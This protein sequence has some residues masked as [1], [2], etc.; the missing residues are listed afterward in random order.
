MNIKERLLEAFYR[1]AG[2]YREQMVSFYPTVGSRGIIECNQTHLFLIS[3]R[4]IL[5]PIK[6]IS[7]LELPFISNL[8]GRQR[9]D[10][11]VYIPEHESLILIEAKRIKQGKTRGKLNT[12][13]VF[14]S[15]KRDANRMKERERIES[16]R[17]RIKSPKIDQVQ[18]SRMVLA[19]MWLNEEE[20][21]K[22]AYRNWLEGRFLPEDWQKGE[23]GISEEIYPGDSS[24]YRLLIAIHPESMPMM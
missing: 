13:I 15:I 6:M 11:A 8:K 21:M 18:I 14:E 1:T 22:Q 2:T 24:S 9:V 16:I 5:Y 3:L 7:W 4:E 10:G 12:D 17:G 19:D 20:N 23:F